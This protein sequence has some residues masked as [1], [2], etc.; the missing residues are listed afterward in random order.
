MKQILIALLASTFFIASYS[1]PAPAG[2]A[3]G[4]SAPDFMLNDLMGKQHSLKSYRGKTAVIVFLSTE[5]PF[6]NAYQNRLLG[7][8]KDYA[9]KKVALIGINSHPA[10]SLDEIR[11]HAIQHKLDFT[12]LKDEDSRVSDAYGAT[13]TPEVFAIDPS[14]VLRY[15]GRIDNSKDP[16]GIKRNDL[17]EALDEMIAG[18]T[19]SVPET[20]SFGC[21]IKLI[22]K[23]SAGAT[24][25]QARG[26]H[27]ATPLALAASFVPQKK[28]PPKRPAPA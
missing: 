8:A 17:R 2:L 13:R 5:C 16:A 7:I 25:G 9:D 11:A 3:I 4:R 18:K 15:H 28:M 27:S 19:V 14:G 22:R 26:R 12:I 1:Q 24:T 23:N 10:E 6:S 20:K 21:P